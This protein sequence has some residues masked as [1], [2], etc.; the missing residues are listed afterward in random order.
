MHFA[1]GA[2]LVSSFSGLG[3]MVAC[4]VAAVLVHHD[5]HAIW[6]EFDAGIGA[7]KVAFF[8]ASGI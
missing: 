4:L 3:A 5:M 7:F 2:L 1:T 8:G 6:M